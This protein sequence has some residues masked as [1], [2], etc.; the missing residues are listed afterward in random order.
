MGTCNPRGEATYGGM[1][2]LAALGESLALVHVPHLAAHLLVRMAARVARDWRAVCGHPIY[3]APV[4]G[5]HLGG[6]DY[7]GTFTD[8]FKTTWPRSRFATRHREQIGSAPGRDTMCEKRL[9]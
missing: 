6:P 1:L 2:H 8:I 4:L 5:P 3:D 9:R 7:N